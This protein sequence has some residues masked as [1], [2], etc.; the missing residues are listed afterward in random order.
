VKAMAPWN[1][2]IVNERMFSRLDADTQKTVLEASKKAEERGWEL[3]AT[4]TS[5]LIDTLKSNG[6][7]VRQPSETLMQELSKIGD[8]LIEEWVKSAGA[9]GEK[10]ISEFRSKVKK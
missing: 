8:Q 9:D 1:I 4:E 3:A 10:I 6:M 7:E 2:V 5:K